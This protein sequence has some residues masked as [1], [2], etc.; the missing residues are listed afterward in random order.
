MQPSRVRVPLAIAGLVLT[1]AL[2]FGTHPAAAAQAPPSS[3]GPTVLYQTSRSFRVPFQIDPAER[4]RRRELQLWSSDDQGRHWKQQGATTPDRPAFNFNVAQDGEYWLA[5]RSVDAQGRLFPADDARIEPS[6]KIIVDTTPPSIVLEPLV[7]SASLASVR[8]EVRDDHPDLHPPVLEYQ[9]E[10]QKAWH[11]VPSESDG[12]P[13]VATWDS[14]FA[15]PLKIRLTALD[16]AGNKSE[17]IITLGSSQPGQ[18]AVAASTPA[19]A[20]APK[21]DSPQGLVSTVADSTSEGGLPPRQSFAQ[22]QVERREDLGRPAVPGGTGIRDGQGG[23]QETG[24]AIY[25]SA[26]DVAHQPSAISHI[27]DPVPIESH[28]S[29]ASSMIAKVDGVP[30]A[31]QIASAPF[32]FQ[33]ARAPSGDGDG[34]AH[35]AL[36]SKLERDAGPGYEVARGEGSEKALSPLQPSRSPLPSDPG[37]GMAALTKTADAIRPTATSASSEITKIKVPGPR[38]LL[39]YAVDRA[40]PDGRPAVVEVWVTGDGGKTWTRQGKDPDRVSPVLVDLNAEGTFGLS[41]IARDADG[42]GDKPPAPGDLPKMWIE[43]EAQ[44][45]PQPP[46]QTQQTSRSPSLLQRALRR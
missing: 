34:K 21:P 17:K 22:A 27:P 40:G 12:E 38:F 32:Q 1:F 24:A 46:P 9:V 11:S 31:T 5:V 18:S 33:P 39:D 13:G 29:G 14:G 41:L 10:G 2:D 3:K 4:A 45:R 16:L 36:S 15:Q 37:V 43:V 28:A 19:P 8:W 30:F 23:L 25:P 42:L 44:S 20:P 35:D 26:Q 6:M 7:R